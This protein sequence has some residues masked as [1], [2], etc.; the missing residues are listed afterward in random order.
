[1][2]LYTLRYKE[3]CN[4]LQPVA[5]TLVNQYQLRRELPISFQ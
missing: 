1:M 4:Q 2:A 5:G 3:A